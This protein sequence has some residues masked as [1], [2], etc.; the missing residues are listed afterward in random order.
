[1][2]RRAGIDEACF[3]E[4]NNDRLSFNE[5]GKELAVDIMKN[6][7]LGEDKSKYEVYAEIRSGRFHHR[8]TEKYTW[9]LDKACSNLRDLRRAFPDATFLSEDEVRRKFFKNACERN[10]NFNVFPG[11]AKLGDLTDGLWKDWVLILDDILYLDTYIV[12]EFEEQDAWSQEELV[13]RQKRWISFLEVVL[14]IR[15]ETHDTFMEEL[16]QNSLEDQEDFKWLIDYLYA[17]ENVYEDSGITRTN[18]EKWAS[19]ELAEDKR[20]LENG[21][22]MIQA[23]W[24]EEPDRQTEDGKEAARIMK[25]WMP[26]AIKMT[27]QKTVH[28]MIEYVNSLLSPETNSEDD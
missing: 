26:K 3:T 15:E 18:E 11:I 21:E 13:K 2:L 8:Y 24:N 28:E 10:G 1:M 4:P 19:R 9:M 12:R 7:K 14:K 16:R 5:D 25:K 27:R 22:Q 6:S 17:Y 20:L 23:L